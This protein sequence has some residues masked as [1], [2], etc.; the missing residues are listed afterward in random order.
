MRGQHELI[1]M[2][3]EGKAPLRVYVET[4]DVPMSA[5]GDVMLWIAAD[6]NV[7]RLDLRCVAGLFAIVQGDDD[8]RVQAVAAAVK[9]ASAKRVMTDTW[10]GQ[11]FES[12]R[13]TDTLG[14]YEWPR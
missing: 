9:R 4:H 10:A 3:M 1:E 6:E 14:D 11:F 12:V 8:D 5:E 2:R 13:V 7:E